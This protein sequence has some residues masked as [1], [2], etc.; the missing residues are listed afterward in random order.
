MG[1]SCSSCSHEYV[2]ECESA[3]TDFR[4]AL[5][6][7]VI[8]IFIISILIFSNENSGNTSVVAEATAPTDDE[9]FIRYNFN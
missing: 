4:E 1:C 9:V 5:T 3:D 7:E 2:T 8:S 6:T